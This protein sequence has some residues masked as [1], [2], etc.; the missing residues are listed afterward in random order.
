MRYAYFLTPSAF[1]NTSSNSI[2]LPLNHHPIRP[3]GSHL[4]TAALAV[5]DARVLRASGD[6]RAS[7]SPFLRVVRIQV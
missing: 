6:D 3:I 4:H 7:E 2:D 5:H 1:Q